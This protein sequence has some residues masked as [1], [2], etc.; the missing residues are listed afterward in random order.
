MY[1]TPILKKFS[2]LLKDNTHLNIIGYKHFCMISDLKVMSSKL[3]KKKIP[4]ETDSTYDSRF[5]STD[6]FFFPKT[7]SDND[8][9]ELKKFFQKLF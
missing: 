8:Q 4:H 1:K 6:D 9:I 2:V 3:Q 7:V 5:D